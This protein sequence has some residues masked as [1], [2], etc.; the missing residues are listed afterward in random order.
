MRTFGAAACRSIFLS[1]SESVGFSHPPPTG[2][3]VHDAFFK[4]RTLFDSSF[5]GFV[6]RQSDL[7]APIRTADTAM[8]QYI[9][10][11]VER[12]I[13]QPAA[14]IDATVRQLV[15]ALL[16]T[17]RCSSESIANHLGVDRTTINRRLAVRGESFSSIVNGVRI[18][19]ARRYIQTEQ[20]SLTETAQLLGFSG[21]AT[22]SRWFR[23]EFETSATSWRK[24]NVPLLL[25]TKRRNS[26]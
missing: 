1:V 16:P 20:R 4:A 7:T 23:T 13:P 5:N 26:G 21:L 22:F 6:L 14:T 25:Q 3:T 15:F 2:R 11:Y 18:E 24:R 10:H 8:P 17:G 19:L 12:V 9:K